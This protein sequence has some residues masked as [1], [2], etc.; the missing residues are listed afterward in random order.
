MI[1]MREVRKLGGKPIQV[2]LDGGVAVKGKL[3]EEGQTWVV[4]EPGATH[5]LDWDRVM[6]VTPVPDEVP[7]IV[8]PKPKLVVSS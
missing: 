6:V 3:R 1:S 7:D 2:F 5:Y 8:V 4:E